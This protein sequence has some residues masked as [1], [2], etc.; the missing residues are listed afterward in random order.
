VRKTT[1]TVTSTASAV[2]STMTSHS[3][4]FSYNP[5]SF[6]IVSPPQP[7]ARSLAEFDR[8]VDQFLG[9]GH[10]LAELLVGRLA[11]GDEGVLVDL[12]HLDAARLDL[13]EQLGLL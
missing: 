11:R 2:I 12:V 13:L 6:A 3:S 8:A 7:P 10:G 5:R 1:P 4:T 9:A